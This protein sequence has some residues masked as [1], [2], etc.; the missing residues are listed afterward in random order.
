MAAG[1]NL[2]QVLT[3]TFSLGLVDEVIEV[4]GTREQ[5]GRL[6]QARLQASTRTQRRTLRLAGEPG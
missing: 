6:L 5:R 4:T 3:W 1:L 2:G